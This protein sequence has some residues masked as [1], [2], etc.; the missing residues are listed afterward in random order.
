MLH[1]PF[2]LA[3]LGF[4]PMDENLHDSVDFAEA[5]GTNVVYQWNERVHTNKTRKA[6]ELNTGRRGMKQ[7][8]EEAAAR[9]A[10]VV[11][12]SVLVGIRVGCNEGRKT[13]DSGF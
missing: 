11:H 12:Y 2:S 3:P 10:E 1:I 6:L 9:H 13:K 7:L 4:P 5:I 8:M